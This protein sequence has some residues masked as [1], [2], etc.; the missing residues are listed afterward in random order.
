MPLGNGGSLEPTRA[1]PAP[2][3]VPAPVTP[4]PISAKVEPALVAIGDLSARPSPPPLGPALE[5]N[6]P[7]EARRRGLSGSAKVRARIDPDG[8]VRRVSLLEESAAGFGNACSR[9]LSGSRWAAP[10]D[11]AGRAVATEIRYTCRFVIE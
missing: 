4:A 10:K 3:N 11:K 7:L 8:V 2:V 9:T 1:R 6:Y 5:R